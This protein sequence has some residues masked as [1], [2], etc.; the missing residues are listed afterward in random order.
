M[1]LWFVAESVLPMFSSKNFIVSVLTFRSLIHLEF[2]FVDGV[3]ECSDFILIHV[4]VQLSHLSLLRRLSFL[5]C[6]ILLPLS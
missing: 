6:I 5:H 4:A 3:R 2:I 1:L